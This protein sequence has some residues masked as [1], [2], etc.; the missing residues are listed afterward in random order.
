MHKLMVLQ[1]V[2]EA[3]GDDR[4]VLMGRTSKMNSLCAPIPSVSQ[5]QE[6]GIALD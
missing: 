1:P 5:L 6:M 4:A 2:T 3:T